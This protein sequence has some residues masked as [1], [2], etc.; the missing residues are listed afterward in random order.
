MYTFKY[1]EFGQ[2]GHGD[3]ANRTSPKL[4]QSLKDFKH[5]THVQ[6]GCQHTM[7]LTLSGY[8]VTLSMVS[9]A[10]ETKRR[11]LSISLVLLRDCVSK[12]SS[13]LQPA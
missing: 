8:G 6:G 13:K 1:G 5:I 10:L 2:L 7:A 3:K 11:V 9:L 4:V 12:M